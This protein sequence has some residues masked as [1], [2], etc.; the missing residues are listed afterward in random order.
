MTAGLF[1]G[2]DRAAAARY[3]FL[4]SVP[5]IT[6][7]GLFELRHVTD[8]GSASPGATALA[9]V[10]AFVVGYASI[11]WLLKFLVTHSVRAFVVY[12]LLVGTVVIVLA[13]AGTI[14]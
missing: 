10:L 14:A 6:L 11:A 8:A 3:S 2:L 7:A 9:T 4:L 1:L 13:A 5:A 12:R